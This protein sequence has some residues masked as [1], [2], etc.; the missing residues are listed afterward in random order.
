MKLTRHA[1]IEILIVI[2]LAT[3]SCGD[4]APRTFTAGDFGKLDAASAN[5]RNAIARVYAVE[6]RVDDLESRIAEL[7]GKLHM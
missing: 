3:G 1:R 7:E 6:Q 2:A 4:S 5:G